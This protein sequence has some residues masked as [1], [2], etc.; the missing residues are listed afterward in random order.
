MP[1]WPQRKRGRIVWTG[2]TLVGGRL[3]VFNS[4]GQAVTLSPQ[5]GEVMERLRLPGSVTLPPAVANRTLFVA[6]DGGDLVALR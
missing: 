4:E 1:R 3:L 6:T 2:P 5:S